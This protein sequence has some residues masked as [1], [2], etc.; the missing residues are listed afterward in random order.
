[1]SCHAKEGRH[2]P[3][4]S[5]MSNLIS[6]AVAVTLSVVVALSAAAQQVDTYSVSSQGIAQNLPP[7]N[8]TPKQVKSGTVDQQRDRFRQLAPVTELDWVV[9]IGRDVTC[10]RYDEVSDY[11]ETSVTMP[12]VLEL[13]EEPAN[14]FSHRIVSIL[15]LRGLWGSRLPFQFQLLDDHRGLFDIRYIPMALAWS[16]A[17][18]DR[19]RS[20]IEMRRDPKDGK[21]LIQ[22]QLISQE[23][24]KDDGIIY[25]CE[26]S[27]VG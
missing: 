11:P 2:A 22:T 18:Y 21:L 13:S 19:D 27:P 17:D 6:F 26:V 4:D 12:T 24:G 25:V 5:T 14:L 8:L 20:S 15:R 16:T 9:S 10:V 7:K 1:M 3:L 23:S